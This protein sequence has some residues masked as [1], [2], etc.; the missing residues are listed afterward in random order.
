VNAETLIET[1]KCVFNAGKGLKLEL[2][3]GLLYKYSFHGM[4][5]RQGMNCVAEEMVRK[6]AV[7]S[8]DDPELSWKSALVEDYVS[9]VF[10]CNHKAGT[11]AEAVNSEV[12]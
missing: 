9:R 5:A 12:A 3:G 11:F 10:N 6:L 4:R 1:M 7:C 8:P 2:Q